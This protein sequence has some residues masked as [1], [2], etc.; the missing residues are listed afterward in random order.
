[1][2]SCQQRIAHPGDQLSRERRAAARRPDLPETAKRTAEPEL[3]PLATEVWHPMAAGGHR[4]FR[5]AS[6][7]PLL[8]QL[9][10]V[11]LEEL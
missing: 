7:V 2:L 1:M 8:K 5:I 10:D 4:L 6:D 9:V 11:A 3:G